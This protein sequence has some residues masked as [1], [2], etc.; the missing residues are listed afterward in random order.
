MAGLLFLR[1]GMVTS[2]LP[3]GP[4]LCRCLFSIPGKNRTPPPWKSLALTPESWR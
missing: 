4:R 1:V 3:T 2:T